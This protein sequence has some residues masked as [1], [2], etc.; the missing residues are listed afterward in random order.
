MKKL[1]ALTLAVL[2]LLT[3]CKGW[4]NGSYV[5]VK[6]HPTD[7]HESQQ[8]S[9]SVKDYYALQQALL[10]MVHSTSTSEVIK[11]AGYEGEA[12]EDDIK[13]AI[14]DILQK[15][16]IA[17]YAVDKITYELGEVGSRRAVVFRVSYHQNRADIQSIPQVG[18]MEQANNLVYRALDNC[19]AGVVFQ[20][21]DYSDTDF[22]LLTQIY[23]NKNPQ[24]VIEQ[25]QVTVN[26]YPDNG[27]ERVVE[28]AFTYQTNRDTL[29]SMQEYV[30][31]VFQA[32]RLNVVSEEQ[33]SVCF[34]LM[35]SFLVERNHIRVGTSI[36]PAYSILRYG[37][38]DSKSFALVFAAMCRNA[39]LE[40]FVVS[41]TK[42]GQPYF[43]NMICQDGVYYHVDILRD[44]QSQEMIRY[45]SDQMLGYVWDFDDYP[46][47]VPAENNNLQEEQ[48]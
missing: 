29:R 48:K 34:S 6:P 33:E 21:S 46:S 7:T 30:A 31:P 41:G 16:A 1:I 12:L 39:Q 17:A 8:P 11:V 44:R 13:R 18:S 37:V 45:T 9:Q 28:L 42:D 5:S 24:L 43:W 15:D 10:D 32:S 2:C 22:A 35:Y 47:S 19:D 23:A 40:C 26:I 38:G 20:V 36:T 27:S 4:G 3:G 14:T 25:P